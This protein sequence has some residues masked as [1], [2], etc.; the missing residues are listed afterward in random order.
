MKYI[1]KVILENFQSHK[2]T[3]LELDSSLN[4]IVG[5]SDQGKTAIIRGIKWALFNEPSGDFFI[6]EGEKDCSVTIIFS[7]NTKIKR[8]R[9]SSKNTYYLYDSQGGEEVFEGFGL[10]V[11][12]EIIDKT[13]MRKV[14][15]DGSQN[16]DINI[17][18]QLEGPFLLAD[19]NSSRA[20]AIGRLVGV[21]IIDDALKDTLRDIRAANIKKRSYEESLDKLEENLKEYDYLEGLSKTVKELEKLSTEIHKKRNRLKQLSS[22]LERFNKINK[23]LSIAQDYLKQLANVEKVQEIK[24]QLDINVLRYNII[25]DRS[26]KLNVIGKEIRKDK[27]TLISLANIDKVEKNINKVNMEKTKIISLNRLYATYK[28]NIEA[29]NKTKAKLSGLKEIDLVE[30]KYKS[31]NEAYLTYIKLLDIWQNLSKINKSL[32]IGKIYIEKLEGVEEISQLEENII[33]KTHRLKELSTHKR[34]YYM[35]SEAYGKEIK[36]IE[37]LDRQL[38]GYLERYQLVLDKLELCPLC[39]SRIDKTK[40]ANIID[41]YGQK[42]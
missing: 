12:Q 10:N 27:E 31:I 5:P 24:S 15:L 37:E 40:I 11:P 2:Y 32:S 22:L 35:I 41:N 8:Y 14:P 17:G 25:Q 9:S 30:S 39:F 34:R 3:E 6:R 21:H 4:V 20:N 7:D 29:L 33:V 38:E 16:K 26:D 19:K 13:G 1:K 23:D 36:K 28:K 42:N 18:E